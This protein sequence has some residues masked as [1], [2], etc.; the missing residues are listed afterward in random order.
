MLSILDQSEQFLRALVIS[1]TGNLHTRRRGDKLLVLNASQGLY[2]IFEEPFISFFRKIKG[3]TAYNDFVS[4]DQGIPTA[5]FIS[6]MEIAYNHGLIALSGKCMHREEVVGVRHFRPKSIIANFKEGGQGPDYFLPILNKTELEEEQNLFINL[7]GNL[8]PHYREIPELLKKVV[9]NFPGMEKTLNISMDVGNTDGLDVLLETTSQGAFPRPTLNFFSNGTIEELER[10]IPIAENALK[11]EFPVSIS[12]SF[13]EP[14]SI[15]AFVNRLLETNIPN[16]GLKISRKAILEELPI[17]A[18]VKKME[19]FA[20][21]FIAAM[22]EVYDRLAW[23]PGHIFMND[24]LRFIEKLR[25]RF[26]H[27]PC[28]RRP[29]GMGAELKVLEDDGSMLACLDMSQKT[30]EKLL[31]SGS[32]YEKTMSFWNERAKPS[33]K[34]SRCVWEY[35]C[36]GGCPVITYEK[37]NDISREDPRCRFFQVLFEELIWKI[38]ENPAMTAKVGGYL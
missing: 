27:H 26:Y 10:L 4:N 37:F 22:D 23:Q 1:K 15:P 36:G 19:G 12:G 17:T 34:C 33:P 21:A 6:F 38:H 2:C 9:C 31:I 28:G 30:R 18:H 25:K 13:Y 5:M 11:L 20:R 8:K 29:C 14:E 32:D 35:F 3:P 24:V 7:R 16:V